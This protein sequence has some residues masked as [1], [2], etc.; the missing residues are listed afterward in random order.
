MTLLVAL[1]DERRAVLLADRRMSSGPVVLDDEYNKVTVLACEDARLAVA[2]TGLAT[3]G[4]FNTSEWLTQTLSNICQTTLCI[5]SILPEFEIRA[6]AAFGAL[7]ASDR[8][9]TF[10]F[11]GFVHFGSAVEP[12]IYTVSNFE[13]GSHAPGTFSTNSLGGPNQSVVVTAGMTSALPESTTQSLYGLLT[14]DLPSAAIVRF[15]VKHL[16]N[17]AR[18]VKSLNQIG[19][20]CTAAIISCQINTSI[21]TTYHTSKHSLKAYG[22]N[23]II[24]N[25]M[26]GFGTEV[27]AGSI[28]AG[29]EIR[30]QDPCWC[31]SG[32]TFKHCHLKKFGGIYV[33]HAAWKKPLT[34]FYRVDIGT[35]WATGQY[36]LVGG[37]YE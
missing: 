12:R 10:L 5:H 7:V 33:R 18:S 21:I 31:G 24:G 14:A 3:I 35:P 2:F 32:L 34:P 13:H 27:M 26:T 8:R 37:G 6:G 4:T 20:H 19:E 15:A 25:H 23:I 36:F 11:S 17:A 1:A 28:L 9:V 16:Q 22:P 30:K 29:P